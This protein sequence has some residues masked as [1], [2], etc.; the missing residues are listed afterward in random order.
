M[1][2][3]LKNIY[4]KS[5]II[6]IVERNKEKYILKI[7]K[8][9]SDI[10]N[11]SNILKNINHPNIVSIVESGRCQKPKIGKY[12]EKGNDYS[13]L[14][15]SYA[16]FSL[17]DIDK[18][19]IPYTKLLYE[20]CQALIYLHSKQYVHCDIKDANIVVKVK[21]KNKFQIQLCDFG[22][23]SH[24]SR[25]S[26]INVEFGTHRYKPPE[27]LNRR[28]DLYNYSLDIW[29]L[30]MVIYSRLYGN[31]FIKDTNETIKSSMDIWYATKYK[32]LETQNNLLYRMLSYDP[33]NR[34]TAQEIYD[35]IHNMI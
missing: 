29:S 23:S 31:P 14:I 11:E 28:L 26:N 18:S 25:V 8:N 24:I 30:G 27:V 7:C 6:Y 17:I 2:K 9:H 33:R 4:N 12:L 32:K 10:T 3:C 35:E 20:L 5:S 13:Y 16:D 15:L 22:I 1:F 19:L 21:D 34:P